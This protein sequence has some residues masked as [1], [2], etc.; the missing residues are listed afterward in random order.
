MSKK[1][2]KKFLLLGWD[3]AEWKVIQPLIEKGLMPTLKKFLEE[4]TSGKIATLDPPFS[5]MLWTSIATGKRAY[6][7]GIMGFIEPTPNGDALRPV[8]STSRKV[9]AIWNILNQSGYKSNVVGWWPSHPAEPINGV[10]VSNFYQNFKDSIDKPWKMAD[11]AVYPPEM[12]D[13]MRR[14]RVHADE[15]SLP[16]LKN[17]IPNVEKL[18][19]K[20]VPIDKDEKADE[21][22]KKRA[23]A[24][25]TR[26]SGVSKNIATCSS[27]HSAGTYLIRNTDWDFS[28]I[29]YDTIDHLSHIGMKFHPPKMNVID[30][31][32]FD[33]FNEVVT[34][35]YRFH[36]MLLERMLE[37]VDDDTTIMILSDHGFHPDNLRPSHLPNEPASPAL[38][39]SPF[40]FFAIRGPGI[41]KGEKIFGA[42][43]LDITP[44]ILHL[45]GLPVGSD[46]EGKVL[47]QIFEPANSEKVDF[48]PSWEAVPGEDGRHKETEQ[49]NTW[50]AQEA[51][52]QLID[53]GYV[54]KPNENVAKGIEEATA[55]AKYY[56]A[57]N[58]IHGNRYKEAIA[59]LEELV[60]KYPT[61]TRYSIRLSHVYLHTKRY[62]KCRNLLE[63]VKKIE[64]YPKFKVMY[65]EGM[66]N[67]YNFKIRKAIKIFDELKQQSKS[68]NLFLNLGRANNMRF[69]YKDAESD[70]LKAIELDPSNN[71]SYHGLGISYLR[72]NM[73][74]KAAEAFLSAIEIHNDMPQAHFSLGETL[75]KMELYDQA[76]EAFKMA[77]FFQPNMIRAHFWLSEIYAKK[78]ENE[79]AKKHKNLGHQLTSG[80]R[81]IV[82]GLQRSGTSLM[83]QL[84]ESS[85]VP[86][87]VDQEKPADEFNPKGYYEF[88]PALNLAQD[89][90]WL[91][92]IEGKAV[93]IYA[94]SITELPKEYKYKVIWVDRPMN[95]IVDSAHKVKGKKM[96]SFDTV[97]ADQLSRQVEKAQI[98]LESMPNVEML[99]VNYK[100][101]CSD[102]SGEMEE[103]LAFLESENEL[104]DF[105]ETINKVVVTPTT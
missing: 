12:V 2:V 16:I 25:L 51:M 18:I 42:S 17:F 99:V 36:D 52:Q 47:Q 30:Q 41:K 7:H 48:I 76:I 28:A 6:D 19:E 39:H 13:D 53:L 65:L 79:V 92:D 24:Y 74:E 22:E 14:M 5:P 104:E 26:I 71:L 96:K 103:I 73:Y 90:I 4:G 81:I 89:K 31:D 87:M 46:M 9:K 77:L 102:P 56:L 21:Q 66:L 60:E 59:L 85:G 27:I 45:Y 38:E 61:V 64:K 44:T 50:A 68:P 75:M 100:D 82:T 37:L 34:A 1:K 80:E 70:F 49:T 20:Y 83:M 84:L 23:F 29:Y 105:Q 43:L 32:A 33:N 97:L 57:R 101:L 69:R 10:M 8:L 35:G 98:W 55:E 78:G 72:R 3:A 88:K 63:E 94:Q 11:G 86:V 58:Y 15:I 93:K 62:L 95:E 54:E 91:K 67:I 40:G